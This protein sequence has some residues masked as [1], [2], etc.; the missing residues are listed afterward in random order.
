MRLSTSVCAN[1]SPMRNIDCTK[2]SPTRCS[3]DAISVK[4]CAVE[5][6]DRAGAGLQQADAVRER[7]LAEDIEVARLIHDLRWRGTCRLR[8]TRR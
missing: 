6:A 2:P 1:I 7:A 4:S 5:Q 3:V 8:S